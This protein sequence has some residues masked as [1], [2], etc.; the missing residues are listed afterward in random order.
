MIYQ[1][2]MPEAYARIEWCREIF[3]ETGYGKKWWRNRG[4]VCFRYEPDYMLYLLR[5]S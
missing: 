5:W 4:Y 2:K 3:G 1:V